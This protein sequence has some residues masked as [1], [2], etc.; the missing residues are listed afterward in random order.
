[1]STNNSATFT[2]VGGSAAGCDSIVTLNLTM[3]TIRGTDV[4]TA[5]DSYTWIDGVTYTASNNTA[6]YTIFGGSAAGCD[7]TVML[8][9]KVGELL[10]SSFI[11]PNGDGKN[12]Y[13]EIVGIENFSGNHLK[14]F[15]RWGNVVYST[16]DYDNSWDG[17]SNQPVYGNAVLP[18]GTY[19][20]VL[21]LNAVNHENRKGYIELKR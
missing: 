6:T 18:V 10:I 11:S 3:D 1:M 21:D 9:L 17:T 4:Q 20:Y 13:W 19:F 15:N 16:K 2:I 5:R 7:S 12:D 14:V 8:D